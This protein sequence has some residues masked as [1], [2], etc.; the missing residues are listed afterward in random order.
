M[1]NL[2]YANQLNN[3]KDLLVNILA[4]DP[5]PD[6]FS[7][8]IILVQSLGMAQWLQMQIADH[9]GIAAHLQFPYPTSFLWQQYRLLFPDLPKENL[10][11][12]ETLVWRLMRILPQQLT[13]PDCETPARYLQPYDQLKCYQLAVKIADLFDQYLVYRPHW[14]IHWE[15]GASGQILAE[16]CNNPGYRATQ[17]TEIEQ[18]IRWQGRLWNALIAGIKSDSDET[19]FNTSHRA[20][21]QQRY[22]D[23]L[24]NLTTAEKQRLPKR[25]FIFGISALP[26]TQ[27]AVLKKLSEHC[28]IHLF[29]TNPSEQFWGDQQEDRLLEKLALNQP[30]S[31][32]EAQHLLD[33]QGNPLL[34]TWGKQGKEFL[35]LL[36]EQEPDAVIPFYQDFESD[37]LNLLNQLKQAI[38]HFEHRYAFRH[39]ESDHSLTVASCHSKM[40]EVEVLHNYLL[41]RFEQDPSLSPKD[42]IVMSADIDS[43]APYI[44]AVFARY[45]YQDRRHIPYSISDQKISV[46][47]PNIAGF[48]TLLSLKESTFTVETVFDLLNIEAIRHRFDLSETQLA[49]LRTW[50]ES[51]GVRAG[52]TI[53]TPLWQNYNA[54]EN[55]LA[56]LLLGNALKADSGHWQ[57]VVGMDES[58]GLAA[59]PLGKLA[60]FL[61]QLTAWHNLLQQPHT[62]SAWQ[63]ALTELLHQLYADDADSNESL[64]TLQTAVD[65]LSETVL[66][67]RFDEPIEIDVLRQQFEQRLSDQRSQLNFLIGRV[68]FCTLLPMRAIPFK[69]V[70]LLG[71]NEGDFPRQQTINSFDLMQYARQKGD[72]AKRDDDRY[73]F[74]E[75][76]LSAQDSLYLSYIGQSLTDNREKLPS[77]LVSQ[78]LDYLNENLPPETQISAKKYPMTPFSPRHFSGE[79]FSYHQEWLDATTHQAENPPF[80]TA[81]PSEEEGAENIEFSDLLA[82]VQEPLKHF[83]THRLGVRF[84]P[85][86]NPTEENERFSLS[87]LD[88][89][90]FL[91]ALLPLDEQAHPN[92]FENAKFQGNLPACHF[93]G[94]T[95]C[96]LQETIRPLQTALAPYLAAPDKPTPF[97]L[98]INLKDTAVKLAG[99]LPP[100]FGE[101]LILWRTGKLRDKDRIEAWLSYLCL[102]AQSETPKKLRYYTLSGKQVKT[103]TITPLSQEEATQQLAVYLTDYLAN[104]HEATWA[105]TEQIAGFLKA[106]DS[107]LTLL[108][109]LRESDNL[110]VQRLLTQPL[111]TA[112]L[113]PLRQR[114]LDWFA[115]MLDN[116]QE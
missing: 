103:L 72:R 58:Y 112:I 111:P 15:K 76:L 19:L 57:S 116:Q 64:L 1:F 113:N 91:E 79:H 6:P 23:K 36:L 85:P 28:Q 115:L 22:F 12:R 114:T 8:E 74:L 101:T 55:G 11:D 49:A 7:P 82:Y 106:D 46:I 83:F 2:Y 75:A 50:I 30:I 60:H 35:N 54:W 40:R 43:Y 3:H 100:L 78:L 108:N 45:D 26:K 98:D 77:V 94:L 37:N 56:R 41:D 5:N 97:S 109:H 25:I 31:S 67:T 21:L 42:I 4:D 84:E 104:R 13:H 81:L 80:L 62:M 66:S 70:C 90:H 18:S 110:Y 86:D 92:Y 105:I 61:D 65:Q 9:N 68:N 44:N 39:A 53:D 32:E 38:L 16:I 107:P 51:A 95:V 52:L 20:Y 102:Q 24:D 73:L 14:L 33:N 10:F 88:R 87:G 99:Q 69:I 17:H 47:D 48:L 93:G 89:Y 63:T 71:M 27:L 29:F 34:A 96:D 59:E